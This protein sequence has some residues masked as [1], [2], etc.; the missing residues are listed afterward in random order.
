MMVSRDNAQML[1]QLHL[2]YCLPLVYHNN[3]PKSITDYQEFLP[4]IFNQFILYLHCCI[5]LEDNVRHLFEQWLDISHKN[6]EDKRKY[7]L[8]LHSI[9]L[10]CLVI[11]LSYL[12][13]I[14]FL[15]LTCEDG[16]KPPTRDP[17]LV[18]LVFIVVLTGVFKRLPAAQH[19]GLEGG[20]QNF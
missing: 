15:T 16:L 5:F 13:L 1:V 6:Y 11:S 10:K 14:M 3:L 9:Y 12:C 20:V 2:A 7:E 8:H 17:T 4:T 19:K 18:L